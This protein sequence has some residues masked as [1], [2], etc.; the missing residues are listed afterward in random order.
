MEVRQVPTTNYKVVP[1]VLGPRWIV[2]RINEVPERVYQSNPSIKV[3]GTGTLCRFPPSTVLLTYLVTDV[4]EGLRLPSLFPGTETTTY[5][6]REGSTPYS[7]MSVR[8]GGDLV[9]SVR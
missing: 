9:S 2:L 4:C 1:V 7:V 3:C 6:T 8:V 5:R